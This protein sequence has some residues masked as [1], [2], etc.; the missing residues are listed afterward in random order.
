V[1]AWLVRRDRSRQHLLGPSGFCKETGL[2]EWITL[3]AE[4]TDTT[5]PGPYIGAGAEVTIISP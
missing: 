5:I 1:D 2:H 3:G 4:P